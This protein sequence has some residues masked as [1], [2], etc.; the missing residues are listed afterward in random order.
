MIQISNVRRKFV[1]HPYKYIILNSTILFVIASIIEMTIHECGHYIAAVLMHA[2]QISLHHNYV[3]YS[4]LNLNLYQNIFIS[5]A[6]PLFSLFIG[7]IF[8]LICSSHSK[9]SLQFLFYMYMSIFGYIGFFGYLLIAPVF[10]YGDTGFIFNAL[11]F[12]IW[13]TI[14]IAITGALVLFFIMKNLTKYFVLCGTERLG[15]NI[16]ERATF[17]HSIIL[18]PLFSGIIITTLL[19]IP[20]PTTLSLIAPICSP[21]TI[22]WTYGYALKQKYPDHSANNDFDNLNKFSPYLLFFLLLVI[23]M[24]RL[25]AGGIY[26]N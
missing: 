7:I 1:E 24:N 18:Y 10:I 11:G 3:H 22:L 16:Q 5:G 23:V 20:V 9:R 8:H 26:M 12:P 4:E 13:L 6:G 15:E 14:T 17:I 25:L 2:S 21:F 19:N